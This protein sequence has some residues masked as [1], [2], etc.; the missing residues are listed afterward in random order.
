MRRGA[1]ILPE[2]GPTKRQQIHPEVRVDVYK[3]TKEYGARR[4]M[5]LGVIVEESLRQYLDPS[6]E[7]KD[8]LNRLDRQGR[9]LELIRRDLE[10]LSEFQGVFAR[11]WFAHTPQIVDSEREAA[12][13]LG[14]M[15]YEQMVDYVARSFAAGHRLGGDIARGTATGARERPGAS[16][17]GPGGNGRSTE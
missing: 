9:A 10:L 2:G 17:R 12:Q 8:I 3:R 1:T 13:R 16:S 14:A 4:G 7:M 5:S 15:R 6:G 11:M